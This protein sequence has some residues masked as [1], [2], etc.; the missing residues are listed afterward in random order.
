MDEE[1]CSAF[2][3]FMVKKSGG[4][5]LTFISLFKT[6]LPMGLTDRNLILEAA[7]LEVGG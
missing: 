2:M 4:K 5:A 7:A 3:P 6:S 1:F